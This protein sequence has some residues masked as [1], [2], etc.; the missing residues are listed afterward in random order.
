MQSSQCHGLV[1]LLH[2]SQRLDC[3][4]TWS[5]GASIEGVEV[6]TRYHREISSAEALSMMVAVSSPSQSCIFLEVRVLSTVDGECG[7]PTFLSVLLLCRSTADDSCSLVIFLLLLLGYRSTF[8]GGSQSCPF[9]PCCL[10]SS[11]RQ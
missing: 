4:I 8:N 10:A 11:N 7:L 6:K 1:L 9:P 2:P 3:F 5:A